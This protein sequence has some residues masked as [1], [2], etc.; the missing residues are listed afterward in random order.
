MRKFFVFSFFL[1]FIVFNCFS[2][3]FN[4][5]G[6]KWYQLMGTS[7]YTTCK[8]LDEIKYLGKIFGFDIDKPSDIILNLKNEPV[9]TKW[10]DYEENFYSNQVNSKY[11][12][13]GLYLIHIQCDPGLSLYKNNKMNSW[14]QIWKIRDNSF[15]RTY[16]SSKIVSLGIQIY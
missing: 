8:T 5:A 4:F 1:F 7:F 12:E 16:K 11:L 14:I 10:G 2:E 9:E 6:L 3:S 13:Q 15:T